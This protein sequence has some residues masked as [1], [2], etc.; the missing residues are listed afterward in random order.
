MFHP[1]VFF[2]PP[3]PPPPRQDLAID[4]I[5]HV[6]SNTPSACALISAAS[7]PRAAGVGAAAS[8]REPRVSATLNSAATAAIPLCVRA[9]TETAAAARAWEEESA[10]AEEGGS[11][12]DDAARAAVAAASENCV[13]CWCCSSC[14]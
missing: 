10:G 12:G 5:C 14:W 2:Q 7:A 4:L 13:C 8:D 3:P 1:P 9:S 11:I 6:A